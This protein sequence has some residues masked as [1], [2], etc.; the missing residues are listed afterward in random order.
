MK[1]LLTEQVRLVNRNAARLRGEAGQ[2]LLG[3]GGRRSLC[4]C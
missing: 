3:V 4:A 2:V 1:D